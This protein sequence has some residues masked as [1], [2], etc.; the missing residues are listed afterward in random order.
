MRHKENTRIFPFKEKN[1]FHYLIAQ[2]ITDRDRCSLAPE[3]VKLEELIFIWNTQKQKALA[4][5]ENE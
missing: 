5:L 2:D 3:R 4:S 1:I